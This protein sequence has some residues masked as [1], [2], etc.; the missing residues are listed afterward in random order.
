MRVLKMV[1]YFKEKSFFMIFLLYFIFDFFLGTRSQSP[2]SF[3]FSFLFIGIIAL[4]HNE[5]YFRLSLY[6]FIGQMIYASVFF[7]LVNPLNF[8]FS[9]LLTAIFSPLFIMI[10]INNFLPS[11]SINELFVQYAI[12]LFNLLVQLSSELISPI[13]DIIPS[14]FLIIG[15]F[16]FLQ[17]HKKWGSLF[18]FV[19][20]PNTLNLKPIHFKQSLYTYQTIH[21]LNKEQIERTYYSRGSRVVEFKN[22]RVCRFKTLLYGDKKKMLL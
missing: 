7:E 3:N 11:F 8:I 15:I 5:S 2:M 13:G 14:L 18:L 9:F 12:R 10:V 16:L 20:S 6:L 21:F 22:K 19:H 1:P 17:N 4:A